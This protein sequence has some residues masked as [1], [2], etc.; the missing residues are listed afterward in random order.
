MIAT[1][2]VLLALTRPDPALTPGVV[3]DLTV[4]QICAT[5]WGHDRRHVTVAM[6]QRVARAYGLPWAQRRFMEF[7]HLIPRSLGGADDVRNLWP[8]P[9]GAARLKDRREQ[10][11]SR[12]VCVGT[13]SLEAAQDEMRRWG[14]AS[15]R[16]AAAPDRRPA[17]APIR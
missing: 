13:V 12:A 10:Q 4:E 14:P 6:K 3:R 15:A 7:D 8:Q 5:T 1:L 17:R 9:L 2:L 11:L 16:A